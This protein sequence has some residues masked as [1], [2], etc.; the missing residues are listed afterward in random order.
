MTPVLTVRT[1]AS[2]LDGTCPDLGGVDEDGAER[3]LIEA[4]FW[5]E[6]T[7]RQPHAHLDRL[8]DDGPSVLLFL[9]PE[10]RVASL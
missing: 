7:R 1:Q 3:L 2:A 8:P 4:N 5:T 9:A 6:L 10:E